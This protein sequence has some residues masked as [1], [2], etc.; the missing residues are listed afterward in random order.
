M[1]QTVT[2]SADQ[3]PWRFKPGQSGNPLGRAASTKAKLDA[4]MAELAAEYGG[5]AALT[6]FERT[7]IEQA[8]GLL[9]RKPSTAED[10]VRIANAVARLIRVVQRGRA[11]AAPTPA[12][13]AD[14]ARTA[15]PA[16]RRGRRKV[17]GAMKG[18]RTP[19][20]PARFRHRRVAARSILES[21]R[22]FAPVTTDRASRKAAAAEPLRAVHLKL[23]GGPSEAETIAPARPLRP[24]G[25]CSRTYVSNPPCRTCLSR[26]SAPPPCRCGRR[27]LG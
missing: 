12:R 21:R 10:A 5:V 18:A 25:P 13:L 6:V 15:P 16:P 26:S 24:R 3:F 19:R 27:F 23:A 2:Q 14:W 22:P 20:C 8:A 4:K 1:A 11:A 17:R 7:L 9:L